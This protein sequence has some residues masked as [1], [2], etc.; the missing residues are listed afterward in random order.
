MQALS[1][2]GLY[3]FDVAGA[4]LFQY[5]VEEKERG[6]VG[7]FQRTIESLFELASYILVLF[8]PH[9]NQFPL[10]ADISYLETLGAA[11]VFTCF[12]FR[13]RI[14]TLD[15]VRNQG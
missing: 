15:E 1:R 11:L 5:L 2:F 8:L 6:V 14:G 9:P 12:A 4:Q 13:E 3:A 10:L 7:G